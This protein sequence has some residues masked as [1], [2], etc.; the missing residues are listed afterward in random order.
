VNLGMPEY[1][2]QEYF[3]PVDLLGGG[4]VPAQIMLGIIAQESNMWQAPRFVLPGV[5][6]NPLIG[7]FYGRAVSSTAADEWDIHWDKADCGYG[8]TQV[9]D[10]MRLADTR[11]PARRRC[12]TSS[13]GPWRWTSPRVGG[14]APAETDARTANRCDH[15]GRD[16]RTCLRAEPAPRTL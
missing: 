4:R 15:A 16:H 3:P 2:P 6:G 7:N 8:V 12:R 10:G 14:Q 9:T 11:S 1:T 13:S 5:T